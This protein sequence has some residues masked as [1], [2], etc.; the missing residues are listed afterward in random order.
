MALRWPPASPSVPRPRATP[1]PSPLPLPRTPSSLRTA[2]P[3]MLVSGSKCVQSRCTAPGCAAAAKD[4]NWDQLCALIRKA[5]TAA[6]NCVPAASLLKPVQSTPETQVRPPAPVCA[7]ARPRSVSDFVLITF[8]TN[9]TRCLCSVSVRF[10]LDRGKGNVGGVCARARTCVQ[11]AYAFTRVRGACWSARGTPIWNAFFGVWQYT[12][13][14]R[15]LP[16]LKMFF[17][18]IPIGSK[19]EVSVSGRNPH[20]KTIPD[21]FNFQRH[22]QL[23]KSML[24]ACIPI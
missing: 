8:G 23:C 15:A 4:K 14:W 7:R 24:P 10:E 18:E 11:C 21:W 13:I 20:R 17:H 9:G 5:G 1:P 16:K 6:A 3:G 22:Q 19:K 2:G 12:C